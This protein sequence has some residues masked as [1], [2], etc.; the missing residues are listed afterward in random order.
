MTP[1]I[2]QIATACTLMLTASP[3]VGQSQLERI[4]AYVAAWNETGRFNGSILVA[5]KDNVIFKKGYGYADFERRVAN[6]PE[7]AFNIGSISKQLTTVLVFQLI[8]EGVLTLDEKIG[9]YLPEYRADTGQRVNIDHLLQHTSGIPCYLRDYKRQSGDDFRLPFP[10]WMHYSK[11]QFIKELTSC[12]LLF[13]PGSRYQY[14]NSNYYLLYLIIERRTGKSL[15]QNLKERIFTPLGMKGSGLLD[16]FSLVPNLALGYNRTPVGVLHAKRAYASNTYGA[17]SIYSTVEDLFI[18]NRALRSGELLTKKWQ[19]KMLTPYRQQGPDLRHAYSLDYYTT[20]PPRF[21]VEMEYTSFNGALPGYISDVFTFPAAD[22]T[23]I[24]LDNTEEFNHKAIAKG[25]LRILRGEAVED[26]KPLAAS[27]I[28]AIAVKAGVDKAL[29]AYR[30]LKQKHRGGYESGAFT[31][32][33]TDQGF[34]LA[35]ALQ[36]EAAITVFELIVRINPH[37]AQGHG[38]LAKVLERFGK[39]E[40]S[41][42]AQQRAKEQKS[43]EDAI[44]ALL[45]TGEIDK[46]KAIVEKMQQEAPGDEMFVSSRIGPLYAQKLDA[47]KID[48]AIGICQVWAMGNPED[49]GPYFSLAI[50]YKQIGKK[51]EARRCLAKILEMDPN[52]QWA[53]HAKMR[54]DELRES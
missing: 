36:A 47:G 20:R 49:V 26:P 13:A 3:G 22:H 39:I 9:T 12:D 11:D 4:D 50:I 34:V 25:I 31:E 45:N 16:A 43:A 40:Q 42:Q 29:A 10:G 5:E 21:P 54:I 44:Y 38:D 46:A 2:F 6:Q 41:K 19:E 24:V 32:V 53:A 23:I 52:G 18:F 1:R 17:G 27:T 15:A 33:L 35:D 48:Q 30:E 37:W 28:A 51:G 7:S 14:S 8:D